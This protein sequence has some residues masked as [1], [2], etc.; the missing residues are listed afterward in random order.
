[1]EY[2]QPGA[3]R[4]HPAA[5]MN[6]F[7]GR[8]S[9]SL[10]PLRSR[11]GV[12]FEQA[13]KETYRWDCWFHRNTTGNNVTNRVRLNWRSY[14]ITVRPTKSLPGNLDRRHSFC[15]GQLPYRKVGGTNKQSS[16]SVYP[17]PIQPRITL[18][19][20]SLAFHYEHHLAIE[21]PYSRAP[22]SCRTNFCVVSR[23]WRE[24]LLAP[25]RN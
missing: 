21:A 25:E 7:S 13:W 16:C 12:E 8:W 4:F 20:S 5:W 10:C 15:T 11:S 24:R 18:G 1:V 6:R 14:P 23:Q 19:W 2:S 3:V 17:R 22:A 9:S